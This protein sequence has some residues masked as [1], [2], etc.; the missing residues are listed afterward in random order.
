WL[1]LSL[2]W[3]FG[4]RKIPVLEEVS[5]T[6]LVDRDPALSIILAARDEERSVG[7]S[8]TSMLAQVYSGTLEIIAV[9]DRS[10]DRTGEILEELAAEHPDRLRVSNV[11]SLPDGWLGKTHALYTGAS[12]AQG[13]WLLFTDADVIFAPNCTDRAVRYATTNGLDH[14]TIPPEI[15]CRSALLRSFVA[16]FTLVF[17]MTQRPWR[18]SDPQAQEHVGVGAFNLIRKDA[19][20]RS[21]THRAIRMR[22]DDDMKLAKLL[23][24]DGFRQGVAYGAGL[25]GVEWHQTL[26]DAVRGLSK[27]MFSGLDY[28]IGATVGGVLMLLLTNVL[29]VFGLLSRNTTGTL[30][31]L[32]ILSTFLIYAYRARHF[33]NDTPWWYAMLHSFGI[34]VFIYAMLRSASTTLARGG[35][36]W[37]GTRYP[38]KDLKDN[39]I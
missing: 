12:Q 17:E 30:C 8:V 33:A 10:T 16:A 38:L 28:R 15:V 32:N 20:E 26:P 4:I 3:L 31:R 22:P 21:G 14:L 6:D 24:R 34:C 5:E 13:E 23:K 2:Q 36:E 39:A 7:E 27:S 35:I 37:R 29:P 11:E 25:I 1:A 18:V 19:Y 9:N